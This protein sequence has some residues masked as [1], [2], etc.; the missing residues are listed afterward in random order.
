MSHQIRLAGPSDIEALMPAA[1]AVQD[2]H[3]A[4][5]PD[6]YRADLA[7]EN[8]HTHFQKSMKDP[9]GFVLM[10]EAGRGYLIAER[11]VKA[12]TFF[13]QASIHGYLQ[14]ISVVEAAQGQGIATALVEEMKRRFRAAGYSRWTASHIATNHASAALLRKAGA[15]PFLVSL[16][17]TL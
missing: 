14:Q 11:I 5:Y 9:H 16:S 3:S 1:K 17:A 4:A 6:L 10:E 2:L 7:D 13:G 15:E 8:W 12:E